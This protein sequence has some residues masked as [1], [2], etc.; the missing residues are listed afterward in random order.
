MIHRAK[1]DFFQPENGSEKFGRSWI[2]YKDVK[3]LAVAIMGR[4]DEGGL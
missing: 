1:Q 3:E 4:R 2:I